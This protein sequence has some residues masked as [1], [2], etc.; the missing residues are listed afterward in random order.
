VLTEYIA[1]EKQ[2]ADAD[3]EQKAGGDASHPYRGSI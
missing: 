1:G 3:G 2:D